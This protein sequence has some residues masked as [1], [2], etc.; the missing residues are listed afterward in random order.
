MPQ[1]CLLCV[2]VSFPGHAHFHFVYAE[3]IIF[4]PFLEELSTLACRDGI[5]VPI[6]TKLIL[7]HIYVF[8]LLIYLCHCK[9]SKLIVMG[10]AR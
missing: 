4:I 10:D 9:T 8:S 5:T 7:K 3:L 6:L 1:V 2:I